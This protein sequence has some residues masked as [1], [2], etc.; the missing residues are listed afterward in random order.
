MTIETTTITVPRI[1][2]NDGQ[3]APVPVA[4]DT[5]YE[6]SVF[7]E[8]YIEQAGGSA[9]TYAQALSEGEHYL[10]QY[11]QDG[12]HT[13]EL[14][15]IEVLPPGAFPAPDDAPLPVLP[16]DAQIIE[17]TERT[18]LVPARVPVEVSE[19][20]WE[21]E[22][23]CDSEG[24]CW[25]FNPEDPHWVFDDAMTCRHWA[26]FSLPHNALPLPSVKVEP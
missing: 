19:R 15:R 5:R 13:L 25:W 12:P 16:E 26:D 17:P 1:R 10:A 7:D 3:A 6:F 2:D 14:R 11:Q 20:P 18:I 24:R 21:R 22:G 8:D 23:W 9:P 4:S